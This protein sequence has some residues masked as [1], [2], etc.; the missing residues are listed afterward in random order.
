MISADHTALSFETAAEC[1][2]DA[3]QLF[4]LWLL[5]VAVCLQVCSEA[6]ALAA[7]LSADADVATVAVQRL[8]PAH[9]TRSIQCS[10]T[11]ALSA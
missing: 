8:L 1:F 7:Q 4:L 10:L 6:S 3:C 9:V 2:G 11:S 5:L